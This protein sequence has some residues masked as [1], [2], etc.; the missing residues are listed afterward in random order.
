MIDLK[1]YRKVLTF[2]AHPDD[3]TLAAGATLRKLATLGADIHV[4]IPATGVHSRRSFLGE[5]EREAALVTL[6]EDCERAMGILGVS[7]ANIYLG[8][9]S[10]NEMDKHSLLEL[11]HW[12]EA[13]IRRVK[14]DV[15]LTHHRFCTNI[16]HQYCHNAVVVAT[17]PMV[18]SRIAV[19]CGEV[20]GST[21]YLRPVQWEPNLYVEVSE[22][23]MAAKIE[24]MESFTSEARPDPHPRS[25]EVLRA[26]AKVRGSESGFSFAESFMVLR[27]FA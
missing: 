26:L 8:H 12:L 19:L 27:A 14:P 23:E 13:I 9:F 3:E 25:P 5:G 4:A 24:A 16:D 21:G 22:V 10:D 15:I 17:R 20:S 7:P 2:F 1:Q 6:R 11:I 18:E